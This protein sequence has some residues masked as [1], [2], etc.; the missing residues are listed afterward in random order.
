MT[1]HTDTPEKFDRAL[2][3]LDG[4]WDIVSDDEAGSAA[5]AAGPIVIDRIA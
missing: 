1:L 3:S 2:D 4:A 5:P